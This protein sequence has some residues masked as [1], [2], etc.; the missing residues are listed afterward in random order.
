MTSAWTTWQ[1]LATRT[2]HECA[3]CFTL[4]QNCRL[5]S[6]L[7]YRSHWFETRFNWHG[8]TCT[9]AL[10]NVLTT[11]VLLK[12]LQ[13]NANFLDTVK[14]WHLFAKVRVFFGTNPSRADILPESFRNWAYF[15]C[16]LSSKRTVSLGTIET[17]Q[18]NTT[19]YS[20]PKYPE[21]L[22]QTW[23]NRSRKKWFTLDVLLFLTSM[24][25]SGPNAM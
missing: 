3:K 20:E 6:L 2:N 7:R 10:Q 11:C 17:A 24:T 18:N 13:P 8:R 12:N 25:L 19:F 4:F 1:N 16:L 14:Q 22:T 23:I 21:L 9:L 5:T 15:T